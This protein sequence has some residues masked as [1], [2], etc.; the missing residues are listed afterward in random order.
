MSRVLDDA[1]DVCACMSRVPDNAGYDFVLNHVLSDMGPL[2]PLGPRA[3]DV[4]SNPYQILYV[5]QH[6]HKLIVSLFLPAARLL[7]QQQYHMHCARIRVTVD[8]AHLMVRAGIAAMRTALNMYVFAYMYVQ[9]FVPACA[10]SS[11]TLS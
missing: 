3:P 11:A 9:M 10:C 4:S 8:A 5:Y 2:E 1:R 6:T 7:H